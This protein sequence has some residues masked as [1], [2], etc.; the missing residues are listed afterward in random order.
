MDD[1]TKDA[2]KGV[3]IAVW[4]C[5]LIITAYYVFTLLKTEREHEWQN[6]HQY[7]LENGKYVSANGH[8]S[9]I[10][11]PNIL[12]IEFSRLEA[13][14]GEMLIKG[15]IG[16]NVYDPNKY[17]GRKLYK[18]KS[19]TVKIDIECVTERYDYNPIVADIECNIES[20]DTGTFCMHGNVA[21]SVLLLTIVISDG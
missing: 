8:K 7:V 4:C 6:I 15:S 21:Y 10:E 1:T 19:E 12:S 13:T 2:I 18:Q 3:F 11:K 5:T 9:K 16:I 20:N 14:H 17:F